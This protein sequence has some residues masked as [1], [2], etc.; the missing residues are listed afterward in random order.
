[1]S[2][3]IILISCFGDRCSDGDIYRYFHP[4]DLCLMIYL[5]GHLIQS[6]FSF[7][8]MIQSYVAELCLSFLGNYNVALDSLAQSALFTIGHLA[9][10]VIFVVLAF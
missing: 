1:M 8:I 6:A 4:N 7:I 2:K 9:L 5:I 3:P 10:L